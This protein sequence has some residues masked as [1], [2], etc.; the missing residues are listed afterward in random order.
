MGKIGRIACIALPGVLTVASLICLVLVFLG[1]LN[2]ND[3]NLRGLYFFKADTTTLKHNV[4]AAQTLLNSV[5][6]NSHILDELKKQVADKNIYDYYEIY[7][8]NYCAGS[9]DGNT[10]TSKPSYCSPRKASFYFNPLEVWGLNGTDIQQYV[11]KSLN[12]GLNVYAKVSKWLYTAYVVAL[13]TTIGSFL[14]G[15]LAIFS[16]WGS[17]VT[18]IVSGVA[19]LFTILAAVTSTVLFSTLTG[20]FNSVLRGYGIHLSVGTRML[21]LDYIAVIFSLAASLFWFVSICCCSGKSSHPYSRD[22]YGKRNP[23]N[24]VYSAAPLGSRGYQPIE[25]HG[26]QNSAQP[27]GAHHRGVEMDTFGAQSPYKGRETAY[28]PFRHERV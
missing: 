10:T 3:P 22:A 23:G 28:E 9:G 25:G 24:G 5:T 27:W 13:C 12:D 4:T 2:K 11:P 8:S 21:A 1:G 15:F 7:L 19:T 6:V 18:A 17:F 16:R 26:H 14:V 20:T